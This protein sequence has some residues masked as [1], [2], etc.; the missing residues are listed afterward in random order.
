MKYELMLKSNVKD[1][2]D[3]VMWI[4]RYALDKNKYIKIAELIEKEYSKLQKEEIILSFE[5][6]TLE[7]TELDECDE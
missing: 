6:K 3:E 4:L 1:F 5:P 2:Y 7:L